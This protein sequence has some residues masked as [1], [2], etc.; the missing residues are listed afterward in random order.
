VS[1]RGCAP[2][3]DIEENQTEKRV[4]REK[5]AHHYFGALLVFGSFKH[6]KSPERHTGTVIG[7][8]SDPSGAYRRVVVLRKDYE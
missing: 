5:I 4:G 7:T 8:V 3:S 1:A 6:S 2:F